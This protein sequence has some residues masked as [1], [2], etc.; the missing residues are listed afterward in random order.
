MME[1][2]DH[3]KASFRSPTPPS[4]V[5]DD[6]SAIAG[7]GPLTKNLIN[8]PNSQTELNSSDEGPTEITSEHAEPDSPDSEPDPEALTRA[9]SGPVYSVFTPGMKRWIIAI[10][11]LTS[12]ISPM[13]AVSTTLKHMYQL[14]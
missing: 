7:Q 8:P 12:F 4:A 13:T 9:P 11:M 5:V 6:A 3:E 10:V 1:F 14:Y 2:H